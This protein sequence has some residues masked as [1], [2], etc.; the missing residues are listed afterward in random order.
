MNVAVIGSGGREHAIAWKLSAEPGIEKVFVLPGNDGISG[1][2]KIGMLDFPALGDFCQNY[3][4]ESLIVGPEIPLEAGITDYFSGSAIKIFG[5]DRSSARLESSKT[6]A[7]EFMKKYGVDT[8]KFFAAGNVSEAEK[9]IDGFGGK[10]VVKFDGLAAGKGVFVCGTAEEAISAVL[11]IFE[12]FGADSKIIIEERLLGV[13]VSIIGVTDSKTIKIF[14]PAQDHKQAFDQDRGPNTGGMGAFCPADFCDESMLARIK[15]KIIGPTMRGIV[16]EKMNYRG[17][18][19]FGVM[20]TKKGPMLLEYN[21]RLGDPEAEVVLPAL[22]SNLNEMIAACHRGTLEEYEMKFNEDYFVDVVLASGGYPGSYEKGFEISG[23][24]NAGRAA[25]VFHSATK[26]AGG[27]FYTSGGRV[28][29]VVGSGTT[30]EK[31]IGAAY[32][33]S[34]KIKFENM[35]LRKDIGRRENRI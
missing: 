30:L 1:S 22:K 10:C 5:P 18:I 6:Y 12:R 15:E 25:L 33:A 32:E 34:G 28:L 7:K 11:G 19:Y 9:I 24:E 31:A 2:V 13:E 16:S 20:L 14:P 29:N 3:G 8:A 23:L 17:F 26:K 35:R 27:R 21:V 4:V